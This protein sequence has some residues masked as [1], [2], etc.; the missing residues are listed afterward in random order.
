MLLFPIPLLSQGTY[1]DENALQPAQVNTYWNWGDV[2]TADLQ[3][4]QLDGIQERN[5]TSEQRA[6]FFRTEFSKL[7]LAAS[8]QNYTFSTSRGTISG[9]NAYA[10]MSSPRAAGTE[11]M[12]ISASWLSR[13][14]HGTL[15]LRGT[16]TVLSLAA[17]LKDYSLWAKDIIFII[18]D[19]Y[20][21]GMHAWLNAYHGTL[22]SNL[23]TDPLEHT[24][25]VIW[26]ALNIDYSSHSFSHLGVFHG[27]R[28]TYLI[29]G[30]LT[31]AY[32]GLERTSPKSGPHQF[33][34]TNLTLYWRRPND[35]VR[36]PGAIRYCRSIA[37]AER[38]SVMGSA[39]YSTESTTSAIQVSLAECSS[40]HRLPGSRHVQ[41]GA[42]PNASI[43]Y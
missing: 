22:P 33:F 34:P 39:F 13:A 27:G 2:H 8:I 29:F 9:N 37:G 12:V 14:G 26:T 40:T 3:L 11:A 25:G 17:F 28:N 35:S 20:L 38:L 43:P 41:W 18:S 23:Y 15:N 4:Y 36:S 31:D 7:G 5:L 32:R 19:D 21:H 24:S 6:E 42:W 16:S 30:L 10:V 1:I